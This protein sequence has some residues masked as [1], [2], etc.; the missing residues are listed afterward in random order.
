M[1]RD[2]LQTVNH[3]TMRKKRICNL[4][5]YQLTSL[6]YGG[7]QSLIGLGQVTMEGPYNT[8]SKGQEGG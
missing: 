2:T 6:T 3:S 1:V 5:Q 4:Q 8:T 7:A